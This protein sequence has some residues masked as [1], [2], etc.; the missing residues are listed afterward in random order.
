[1]KGV[2]EGSDRVRALS[3]VPSLLLAF[4]L[5]VP[6][7]LL[8]GCG[9]DHSAGVSTGPPPDS[10]DDPLPTLTPVGALRAARTE[11]TPTATPADLSHADGSKQRAGRI[12]FA[13]G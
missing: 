3:V 10:P 4:C 2:A 8:A 6:L 1:M 5:T 11:P 7:A 13:A 12:F 9:T